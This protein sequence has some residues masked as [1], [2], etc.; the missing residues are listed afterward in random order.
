MENTGKLVTVRPYE[1]ISTVCEVHKSQYEND[2]IALVLVEQE[3]GDQYAVA[4][5]NLPNCECG[6]GQAYIKSYSENQGIL[7]ALMEAGIVSPPVSY[8]QSGFVEIP[9]CNVLL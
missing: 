5:T 4:T 6:P 9:L 8:V 2:R 3:T 1:N 7:E